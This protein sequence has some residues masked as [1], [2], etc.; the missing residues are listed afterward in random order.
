MFTGTGLSNGVKLFYRVAAVKR[1]VR[2]RYRQRIVQLRH[3]PP[4]RRQAVEK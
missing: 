2:G 3:L 1:E 4:R